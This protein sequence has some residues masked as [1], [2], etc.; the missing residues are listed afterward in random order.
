MRLPDGFLR[1]ISFLLVGL[2]LFPFVASAHPFHGESAGGVAGFCHPWHGL[3]HVL[4]MVAVG[5][6]AA[7]T[8]GRA[9]WAVPSSFVGIMTLGGI[10]GAAGVGL[11][12]VEQGILA[13]VMVMGLLIAGSARLPLPASMILVGAFALFHGHVHGAEGAATSLAISYFI[14]FLLATAL[15]HACGIALALGSQKFA[16]IPLVRYAGMVVA[17]AGFSLCFC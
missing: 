12:F 5:L 16:G 9:I 15:L 4:A 11:P 8:G 6:W 2:F 7:Q 17:I 13:S 10:L 3:D 1:K 14:G